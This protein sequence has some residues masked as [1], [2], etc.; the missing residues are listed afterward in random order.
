MLLPLALKIKNCESILFMEEVVN[1]SFN[2]SAEK[3]TV[4]EEKKTKNAVIDTCNELD[5]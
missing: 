1:I 3:I 5:Q 4:K 2:P